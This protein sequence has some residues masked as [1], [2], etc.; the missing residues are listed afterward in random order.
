[1]Q[2][3]ETSYVQEFLRKVG[4]GQSLPDDL[5]TR[6]AITLPATDAEIVAQL[7]TVRACWTKHF[8]GSNYAAKAAKLC[9]AEDERL[10]AQHGPVM[11]TKA[12]WER[13]QAERSKAA[14]DSVAVLASELRRAYGDLGVVTAARADSLAESLGLSHVDA[15][16]AVSQAG[17]TAVASIDLLKA[18]PIASFAALQRDMGQCAASSVPDLVHPASGPFR[19][20]ERYV[21]IG[22]PQKRL[23][24]LAVEAQINLAERQGN[25][26]TETAHRGALQTLRTA[27]RDGIDLR[28]VALFHL[29][30]MAEQQARLSAAL[31][32]D[33]L[34]KAGLDR[35][36]AVALAVMLYD[37]SQ[38]G[39][40]AGLEQIQNLITSGSLNEASQIAA[41]LPAE[42]SFRPEAV[43][44]VDEARQRLKALLAEVAEA[45]AVPDEVRAAALLREAAVISAE[46]AEQALAAVSLPP[47]ANLRAVCDGTQV[48]LYWQAATGHDG[49]TRYEVDRSDQR[50][51]A[52]PGD[53]SVVYRGEDQSCT[54]AHA[55]VAR[56][57]RYCV[58]A[59]GSG[60]PSSRPAAVTVTLIPPVSHLE[61]TVGPAEVTVH[62]SAHPDA[63]AVLVTSAARGR[64][65]VAVPVRGSTCQLT[66][67][68]EGET[69]DISVVAVYRGPGGTELRSAA[70]QVSAT[71]RSEARPIPRLRAKPVEAGGHVRLRVTWTPVDNSE[72]RI[73]R[74]A[75]PPRWP[76]GTWVSQDDMTADGQEV[77]GRRVTERAEVGIEAEVPPGVHHLLPF[78][79]GGTGI[80]V[81]RAAAVGITEPVRRLI[82]TPFAA[83]ATVSW[84]WPDT[85]Q[86]AEVS[87]EAGDDADC[88][89]ISQAQYRSE[90]GA[91]VPLRGGP[92][93][94]E[95]RAVI[96]AEGA[97]FTSPPARTVV[98]SSVE[99]E[100]TY[101]VARSLAVGPVGGRPT[102]VTFRSAEG[103]R[104]VRVQMIARPGPVMP[105]TPD[106][107]FVLLDTALSLAPG[108]TAQHPVDMPRLKRPYWVRCFVVG[109]EARLLDPPVSSLKVS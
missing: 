71:P 10:R 33:A 11:E 104:G 36:D 74:L 102:G 98:D 91:R 83:H 84:E 73:M 77:T 22:D 100:I 35:P 79:I 46:D 21:C 31:A 86:L 61:A 7:K 23:D 5:I 19:L 62:W 2:F 30:K 8:N 72:V 15:V 43:R 67:L 9:R 96:T 109:G 25:S 57:L 51:P 50:A 6:Y 29:M 90:G 27:L 28:D 99:P 76:F 14:Q 42:S 60:R 105:A 32:A 20:L 3:D 65:P 108:E 106:G 87:W 48:K 12:W 64:P 66:G 95:V 81:G 13:K 17:L 82:V 97:S 58:F 37:Q 55:P 44:L 53:G 85:A 52:A 49:G 80:V 1:M 70:A 38:A 78:S 93:T 69:Q 94:I 59:A 88:F 68:A 4:R 92:C 16:A 101:S 26:A 75:A 41:S 40:A 103:C 18:P 47:P 39:Q 54:D 63:H 24:V 107:A 89:V 34:T 45:L 56:E